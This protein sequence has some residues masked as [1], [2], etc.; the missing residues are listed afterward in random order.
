[1][2]LGADDRG[3]L[4]QEDTYF[5]VSR[6]RLKLRRQGGTAAQLIAYE[7]PDLPGRRESRYRIVEVNDALELKE[8][9][10]GVLD[11]AAIVKKSRH[12]FVFEG[13]RIHL[14]QVEGLGS[15]IEFEGVAEAD[16]DL[17]R[18]QGLLNELQRSFYI[19]DDDLLSG[20]Y[21]DLAL[22]AQRLA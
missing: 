5:R 11:I 1:M 12:L 3:I 13:V 7:R 14:D 17:P 18:F 10:A 22:A 6:G 4:L 2:G 19:E 15:F 16:D 8:A 20:S 21:C 9:L